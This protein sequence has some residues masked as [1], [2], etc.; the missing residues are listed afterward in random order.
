MALSPDEL[1]QIRAIIRSELNQRPPSSGG[2]NR[3]CLTAV[4]IFV[5]FFVA[6]LIVHVIVIA[7]F[8]VYHLTHSS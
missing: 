7:G 5:G 1:E 8:T 4:L 2:A 6:V 3:G